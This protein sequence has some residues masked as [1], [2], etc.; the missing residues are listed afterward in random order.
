[1]E[2]KIFV[3]M[4]SKIIPQCLG[5]THTIETNCEKEITSNISKVWLEERTKTDS[6]L[7]KLDKAILGINPLEAKHS[8]N[9]EWYSVDV[10]GFVSE[11]HFRL[12]NV[13]YQ[14]YRYEICVVEKH[15]ELYFTTEGIKIFG[16]EILPLEKII[17]MAKEIETLIKINY[18]RR[19]IKKANENIKKLSHPRRYVNDLLENHTQ[20]QNCV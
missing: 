7:S 8:H 9:T 1:M 18:D 17:E 16:D 12:I 5:V 19:P 14:K 10:W 4:E 2:T 6:P 15:Q 3:K 13:E 20:N 11:N